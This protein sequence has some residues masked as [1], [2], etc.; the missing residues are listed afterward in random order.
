MDKKMFGIPVVIFV[1]L[2]AFIILCN[3][4]MLVGPGERGI[5]IRLGQVQ[6]ESYGE[7]L[8]LI[9]PFIQNIKEIILL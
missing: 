2:I 7:G 4:F 3:P 8:H 9:F 5:K 1:L 6:H